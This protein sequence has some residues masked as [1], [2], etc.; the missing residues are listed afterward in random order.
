MGLKGTTSEKVKHKKEDLSNMFDMMQAKEDKEK[1]IKNRL[2]KKE[3]T[4]DDA[5]KEATEFN[6]DAELKLNNM[7]SEFNE[8]LGEGALEKFASSKFMIG[9]MKQDESKGKTIE[10]IFSNKKKDYVVP[11]VKIEDESTKKSKSS[12]KSDT[13][14]PKTTNKKDDSRGEIQSEQDDTKLYA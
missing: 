4:N 14:K 10:E 11:E 2:E 3:L 9:E 7:F 5:I 13:K 8:K 6:K 12:N 1:D